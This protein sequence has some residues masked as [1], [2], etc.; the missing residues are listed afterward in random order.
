VGDGFKVNNFIPTVIPMQRISPF[1]MM[2]YGASTYFPPSD[3]PKGVGSHPHRGFETVTIAFKGRVAH[4]DSRGN[5]GI[6]GEGEVQWMTAGSGILHKEYHEEEFSKEGGDFQMVQLWVN[7]PAKHKMTEPKYQAISKDKIVKIELDGD[8]GKVDL[9][10]GD[11]MDKTGPAFTFSPITLFSLHLKQE[12]DFKFKIPPSFN[13]A[14]LVLQGK[15]EINNREV[16]ENQMC[17]MAND[18][19]EIGIKTSVD[20]IILVLAG[21]P[22][23]EPIV[24]YGPFLMNTKAEIIQAVE[25]FQNGKFGELE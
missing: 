9:I 7:L 14:L 13:A 20:S 1:V 21:E 2:D 25:D 17:L 19:D 18:A 4:H 22:I 11:F 15:A 6:I 23:N 5:S 24:S 16:L 8:V 3:I 12:K 10:A